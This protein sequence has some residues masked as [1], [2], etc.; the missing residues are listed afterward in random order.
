MTFAR[1][2]RTVLPRLSGAGIPYM[3]TGAV[4]S[5]YYGEPRAT[6]DLD[7][8]I[9]PTA[10]SLEALVEGLTADGFYVDR[11]AAHEALDRRTQFNAIGPDSFKVDFVIR[12]DRPFSALEFERRQPADLLG[13]A[14]FIPTIEDL[15]VAKLEWAATGPSELQL[16]DVTGIVAVAGDMIDYAYVLKWIEVLKLQEVWNR[17]KP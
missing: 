4:A 7:I 13:V 5:S 10:R 14:G 16:R 15:I 1:L 3:V 17:V 2:V 11:D 12:K 6:R 8:V 9:E